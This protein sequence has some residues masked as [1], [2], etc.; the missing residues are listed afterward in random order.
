ML[1]QAE[2]EHTSGILWWAWPRTSLQESDVFHIDKL[3]YEIRHSHI[4][5]VCSM[6]HRP[7]FM[8]LKHMERG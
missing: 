3:R 4:L 1:L 2:I 8:G 6:R 5:A 7:W